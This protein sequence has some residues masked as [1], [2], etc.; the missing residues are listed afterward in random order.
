MTLEEIV[1]TLR[2][3]GLFGVFIGRMNPMHLGHQFQIEMLLRAFA[4]RHL[5]MIGSCNKDVSIRHLFNYD[6]RSDFIHAV[7]P[8]A[9][10]VPL[11]DFGKNEIW[12]K[13]IDHLIHAAGAQ[14]KDV[15]FIG[16]C[17]E[18]VQF[19]G[20]TGRKVHIVNRFEGI[21]KNVSGTEVRDALISGRSLEGMIDPRVI[22]L[23]NERFAHRWQEAREK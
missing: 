4:E 17:E 2:S 15:V 8:S 22:P 23:V 11:P 10:V 7:H 9:R 20:G 1:Q 19:Y 6:D 21:T 18:D 5:V 16:G 13:A 14:P 3:L 12:F